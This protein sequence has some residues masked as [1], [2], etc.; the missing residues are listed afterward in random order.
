MSN[1][2]YRRYAERARAA[3]RGGPGL[4][5]IPDEGILL[6]VCAGI[7]DHF[8]LF[9][10]V[11]RVIA[12]VL[13]WIATMPVIIAYL[14]LGMLLPAKPLRY[15]GDRDSEHSFWRQRRDDGDEVAL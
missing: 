3:V 4:Y 1:Y 5:K 12:I 8:G 9:T 7:A 2:R 13:L 14:L 10:W 11:V 15:S 6:G